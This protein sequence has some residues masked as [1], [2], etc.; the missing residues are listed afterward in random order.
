MAYQGKIKNDFS[1]YSYSQM[2]FG[3][4]EHAVLD[5]CSFLVFASVFVFKCLLQAA[6]GNGELLHIINVFPTQGLFT[7]FPI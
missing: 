3:E 7:F 4:I 6:P 2:G 5:F 1:R